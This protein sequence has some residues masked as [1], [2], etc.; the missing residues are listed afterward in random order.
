MS[1]NAYAFAN[2]ARPH[3]PN[4]VSEIAG[5]MWFIRLHTCRTRQREATSAS[6]A[7]AFDCGVIVYYYY[8][9][10]DSSQ[11]T[12]LR[13]ITSTHAQHQTT[14]ASG[15][16]AYVRGGER[17]ARDDEAQRRRV[18]RDR[19]AV[20]PHR[21]PARASIEQMGIVVLSVRVVE[22]SCSRLF[23]R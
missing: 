7:Y 9:S 20:E 6:G 12:T 10:Q 22:L 14:H 1:A 16:V 8:Y 19:A 13:Y 3:D 17:A 11:D 23:V 4:V 15:G 2:R 18:R 21:Q 5:T